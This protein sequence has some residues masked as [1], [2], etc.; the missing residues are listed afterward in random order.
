MIVIDD[1][2]DDNDGIIALSVCCNLTLLC[3]HSIAQWCRK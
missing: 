2:D 3:R 1:D